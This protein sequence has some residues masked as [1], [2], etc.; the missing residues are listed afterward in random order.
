MGALEEYNKITSGFEYAHFYLNR[1]WAKT[2]LKDY[3]GA[4]NEFEKG[5]ALHPVDASRFYF[6][7]G[8]AKGWLDDWQGHR[9]ALDK[10]ISLNPDIADYYHSRGNAE[11]QLGDFNAAIVDYRKALSLKGGAQ[12]AASLSSA[13]HAL[14]KKE[15]PQAYAYYERGKS[16][17]D[18]SKDYPGAINEFSKAIEISPNFADYYSRRSAARTW[19][20]A[21]KEAGL[22][23]DKAIELLPEKPEYYASR[24]NVN[25]NSGVSRMALADYER[26]IALNPDN[27]DYIAARD[28]IQA[29]SNE[30]E[31]QRD[32]FNRKYQAKLKAEED[33]REEF[34]R[35]LE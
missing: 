11:Y 18:E 22:D 13:M 21:W 28:K 12:Y 20:D 25:I 9:A 30:E 16:L 35:R 6:E 23:L 2:Y 10:A 27:Q 34:K 1:G 24:A 7:V 31:R 14:E 26:A 5:I 33:A 4:I 32:E 17:A 19:L 29:K 15:H 8:K 3:R